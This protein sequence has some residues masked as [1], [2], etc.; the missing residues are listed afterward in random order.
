MKWDV[1]KS[2]MTGGLIFTNYKS[3]SRIYVFPDDNK[4]N[5]WTL[6]FIEFNKASPHTIKLHSVSDIMHEVNHLMIQSDR[7]F[8]KLSHD[9]YPSIDILFNNMTNDEIKKYL[10]TQTKDDSDLNKYKKLHN[11]RNRH[12]S[13]REMWSLYPDEMRGFLRSPK[14]SNI[15]SKRKKIIKKKSC[16]CK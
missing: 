12:Q 9:E 13:I 2:K 3:D 4:V 5:T 11:E 14:K 8:L 10:E 16:R 7:K 15:K 6:N 1:L